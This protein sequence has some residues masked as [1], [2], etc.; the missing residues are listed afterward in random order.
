MLITIDLSDTKVREIVES[1]LCSAFEGGSNLWYRIDGYT[2]P[3]GKTRKSMEAEK[4]ANAKD[5]E[6][7]FETT[8]FPHIDTVLMGGG[9]KVRDMESA[10]KGVVVLDWSKCENALRLMAECATMPAD[11]RHTHPRHWENVMS[12]NTDAETGDVFLQLAL[13]GEVIYG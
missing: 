2:Y 1:L 4:K 11:K 9:C 8:F 13:W 12:E 7:S 6:S 5:P 3:E 10:E